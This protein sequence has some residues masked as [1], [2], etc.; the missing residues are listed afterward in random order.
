MRR[1]LVP[2]VVVAALSSGGARATDGSDWF[3]AVQY[4]SRA[5]VALRGCS[6]CKGEPDDLCEVRRGAQMQPLEQYA[7]GRWPAPGRLKLL[8]SRADPDC[9]VPA[10][11]AKGLL[12]ASAAV[13][14]AAIRIA[15]APPA[16][17]LLERVQPELAVRG[18]PRAPQRRKGEQP[19]PARPQPSSLR[20]A[21][22]CWPAERGWPAPAAAGTDARAALDRSNLCEWWLL[23]VSAA[24]EP[25]VEGASFPLAGGLSPG[26]F[27][28][29]DA[30]WP[31]AF[32]RTAPLDDAALLGD[33]T[34]PAA[35]TP[36]ATA[37]PA[38]SATVAPFVRCGELARARSATLDRFDQWDLQLRGS[39]SPSLDRGSWTLN[40]AAWVGH[41]PELGALRA[42]L[43]QQLGCAVAQQGECGEEAR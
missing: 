27:G 15:S 7:Q 33:L 28:F 13:E 39:S 24:G 3:R 35:A 20:L 31:R 23:P 29:G 26:A 8:R 42:A 22:V 25:D 16:A 17:A 1:Q 19:Q 21:V 38:P 36:V 43:E 10:T 41:C 30:R 14:L 12:G 37:E 32:D 9:A 5:S 34:P 18:W 4:T 6:E 2:L 11:F 40:A